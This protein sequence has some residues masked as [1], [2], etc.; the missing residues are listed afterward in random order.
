MPRV[1]RPTHPNMQRFAMA[2]R[3]PSPTETT[4]GSLSFDYRVDG[5]RKATAP[6]RIPVGS[7]SAS[8]SRLRARN[9]LEV[10]TDRHRGPSRMVIG[11][12]LQVEH[13]D[14]P[15]AEFGHGLDG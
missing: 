14:M 6:A 10:G 3:S 4:R 1:P 12:K 7:T 15:R 9:A 5:S 11:V 8:G 2:D 13:V